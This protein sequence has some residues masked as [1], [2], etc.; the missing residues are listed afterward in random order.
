MVLADLQAQKMPV[1]ITSGSVKISTPPESYTLWNNTPNPFNPSTTISYELPEQAHITL[2]VYNLLGQEI[3]RLVDQMQQ[4][5]RY[6]TVWS[7]IDAQ[8]H[9]VASGLYLYRLNSSTGYSETRR[10]TLLK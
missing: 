1:T 3:I 10:M 7:G 4:P 5:G 9:A 6:H 2:T 8:D